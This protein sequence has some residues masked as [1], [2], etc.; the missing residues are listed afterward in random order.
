MTGFLATGGGTFF[1]AIAASD[2]VVDGAGFFVPLPTSAG[3]GVGVFLET[4][5]SGKGSVFEDDDFSRLGLLEL[6]ENCR[7]NSMNQ[8]R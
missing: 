4:L 6:R 7:K 2:G 5:S 3:G 8:R 1:V